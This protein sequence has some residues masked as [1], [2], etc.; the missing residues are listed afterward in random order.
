MSTCDYSVD[1]AE[2]ALESARH[3]RKN[4]HAHSIHQLHIHPSHLINFDFNLIQVQ[5]ISILIKLEFEMLAVRGR[6]VV[7]QG[8][9]G[10]QVSQAVGLNTEPSTINPQ[11]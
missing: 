4:M 2:A 9:R 8:V 6:G 3:Q 5:S 10:D 11:I 7:I 1:L